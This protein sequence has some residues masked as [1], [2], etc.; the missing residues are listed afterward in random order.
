MDNGKWLLYWRISATSTLTNQ[1]FFTLGL[2]PP[3]T[4]DYRDY[5]QKL[6]R[7][8]GGLARQGY[9]NITLLWDEMDF[10]QFK[11]LTDIVEAAITAGALY[12]TIDKADG[13]GLSNS[14]I[15]VHGIA[16]PVDHTVVSNGRG[17]VY[18]NVT[19]TLTNI[20][21]DADPSTVL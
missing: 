19:L 10:T 8:Q 7:S 17:I 21:V 3:S 2:P 1:N 12:A 9:K 4:P 16:Q 13:T 11:T 5:A 14:F 18:Q 6:P 15:D 20:T